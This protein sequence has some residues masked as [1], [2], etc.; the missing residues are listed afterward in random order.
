MVK[1]KRYK[2]VLIAAI[3]CLAAGCVADSED[4]EVDQVSDSPSLE[5]QGGVPPSSPTPEAM[6][7]AEDDRTPPQSP[8]PEAMQGAEDD[9]IERTPPSPTPEAMQ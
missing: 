9:G 3:V 6:Q 2:T 4:F 5:T 1:I 8:T 7:G